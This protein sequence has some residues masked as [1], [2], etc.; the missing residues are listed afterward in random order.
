[1]G[2]DVTLG[3]V[4][5]FDWSDDGSLLAFT[6]DVEG[7]TGNG[8]Q[9]LNVSTGALKP[10]DTGDQLYS[11]LSW[12]G[13]SDDLVAFRSRADSAFQ[14]TSY[15]VIAWKGVASAKPVKT[16]YDFS[17][18]A[19]FP[20]DMRVAPYRVPLWSEDGATLFFGIAP[21]EAR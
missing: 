12:R 10:L 13:K 19:S 18:D 2:T 15:A 6:I 1:Q 14:D 5:D 17:A 8:V 4:A 7:H 20:R 16:V 21:R 3:N 11:N 9:V